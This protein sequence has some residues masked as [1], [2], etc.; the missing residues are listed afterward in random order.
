MT[1]KIILNL[2]NTLTRIS[3]NDYGQSVFNNQVKDK[4]SNTEINEIIFP[5]TVEGVGISFVKGLMGTM[6]DKYGKEK[7]FDHFTFTS[8]KDDVVKSIKESIIY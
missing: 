7:I 4:I 3:G 8:N 5:D 6:I 1:N 2:P